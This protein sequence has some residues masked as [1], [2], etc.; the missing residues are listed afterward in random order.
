VNQYDGQA[1]LDLE[2][3]KKTIAGVLLSGN[4]RNWEM[5]SPNDAWYSSGGQVDTIVKVDNHEVH[6]TLYYGANFNVQH[7]FKPDQKLVFNAD[8]LHYKDKNPNTYDNSYYMH[9]GGLLYNESVKSDKL[10]PLE[11][12][13][14]SLDYNMK[15]TKKIE[16]EA[17]LKG[18]SSHSTNT[19]GVS[20]LEQNEWIEDSLL[21]G[22]HYIKEKIGAAYSSFNVRFSDKTSIKAGLRYEYTHTRINSESGQEGVARDYGNLFPS[23]FFMHSLK[24]D[25]SFNFSYSKRIWR[26]SYSN[27]AP[28][29]I[30]LDPKTFQTGNPALQPCI[31]DAL[32]TSFTYK[33][34][35][36]TLSYDHMS[37]LINETPHVD[38]ASNKMIT[39]V[40]NTRGGESFTIGLNFPV[41]VNSW[42][43]MQ[44]NISGF[45]REQ[46]SFYKEEVRTEARGIFA[47]TM[48]NFILPKDYSI[49]ISAYYNSGG[50]W[51]L[52]KFRSMGSVDIGFQKKLTKVRATL[53]LNFT[54]IFNSQ[55]AHMTADLPGQ[56]LLLRNVY[57]FSYPAINLSFSKNFGND[58][59]QDK[60]QRATG[61]EDEKGRAN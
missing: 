7:S 59:I 57:L 37:N 25:Q 9:A 4:Y 5:H 27:L 31:M 55:K 36:I 52:Y 16:M 42:W 14:L 34:K 32:S 28:Y 2:L 49:G 58:K 30:F 56:N 41:K 61:A 6:N 43:N 50:S 22:I 54:N 35:I 39:A 44:N 15:L 1:G 13:V 18:S 20:T 60:R 17:G 8:Y 29:V 38:E 45:W 33:S 51:G 40:R 53:A 24:D 48:Q 11:F 10:T 26:P 3:S 19:V 12:F 21:S 47:N 46:I 23:L